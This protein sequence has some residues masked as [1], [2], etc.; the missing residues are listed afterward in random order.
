MIALAA[1]AAAAAEEVH[2]PEGPGGLLADTSLWV[3][4]AF[5]IVIVIM[6][7]M[8]AFSGL[9]RALDDR[10][11]KI[12]DEL[13]QAR[14]LREEAQELLAQYQRRQRE[15]EE[16][17]AGIV[18]RARRDAQTLAAET[19][20][21]IADQIARRTRAAEEKIARAE[22]QAI[23]EVRGQA[24]DLAVE[25]ARVIIR[26]RMDQGAQSALADRAIA[27]VADKLN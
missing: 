18:E 3:L 19:R 8:G 11:R 13:D 23:A 27:G 1:M 26:E 15:A 10:S 4:V 17:A 5:V 6:Q 22:A 21:K 16:E 20:V 25:I 14:R 12:A 2:A 7:R 24:A 9:V